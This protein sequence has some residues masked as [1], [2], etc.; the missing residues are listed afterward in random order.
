MLRAEYSNGLWSNFRHQDVVDATPSTPLACI[1][2]MGE[3]EIRLYYLDRQH[4]LQ[5]YCYSEGLGW[6]VGDVGKMNIRT[7]T[8]T[9]LSAVYFHDGEG[10][11]NVCVYYQELGSQAIAELRNDGGCWAKGD[12]LPDALDGT[13]IAAVALNLNGGVS[14]RVYYQ[15]ED[16]SLKDHCYDSDR[17]WYSG[18]WNPGRVPGGSPINALAYEINEELHLRVCWHN[19]QDEIVTSMNTGSWGP[20]T[21]V[22]GGVTSDFQ[23]ALVQWVDGKYI[24]LYY[25]DVTSGVL[26][27]KSNCSNLT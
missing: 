1:T 27:R 25:Q 26:L 16:L 19:Q 2:W 3:K 21:K 5:E 12:R 6:F 23:F 4:I 22:L 20:I 14:M 13:S 8:N 24:R 15:A 18:E 7:S 17:G 9:R 10:G 11:V